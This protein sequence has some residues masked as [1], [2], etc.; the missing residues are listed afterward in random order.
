M[1]KK[2]IDILKENDEFVEVVEDLAVI[3]G[4][5][6][7]GPFA[8][9]PNEFN[10]SERFQ[11]S[12]IKIK[13]NITDDGTEESKIAVFNLLNDADEPLSEFI[14]IPLKIT[15]WLVQVV[16]VT[17]EFTGEVSEA[18]RV[19]LQD[20]KGVSYGCVSWGIFNSLEKL[21]MTFPPERWA[22]GI[23]IVIKNKTIKDNK[24]TMIIKLA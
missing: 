21:V 24:K 23:D 19:I 2:D 8:R 4:E 3:E 7:P 20:V 18:P 1:S 22:E 15:Q 16:N 10:L 12:D 13:T 6:A 17:S 9:T 11:N 14:G 5:D